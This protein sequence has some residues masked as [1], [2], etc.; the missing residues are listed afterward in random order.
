MRHGG[1]AL[2]L[3][4]LLAAGSPARGTAQCADGSPPPCRIARPALDSARY[5]ILPFAH[6]EG[7]QA[8][9][10]LDGADCAEYLSESFGR[11]SD[12]RLI[13]KTRIYDA[14]ERRGARAPFRIAFGTGLAIARELGAGRVV[15]GQLWSSADTLHLTV[16]VY[17]ASRGGSP[18]REAK[19]RVAANTTRATIAFDALADSLLGTDP[20]GFH[21]A[22]VEETHSIGALR[23]YT[24]GARAIRTWD[25]AGATQHLRAAIAADS[26][27]ARAYVALGQVLLWAADSTPEAMR[28]RGTIARRAGTLLERLAATDRSL[29]LAQQAMFERR[30]PDACERY[31]EVLQRDSSDF[32][33]W[34]GLAQCNAE[35]PVVIRDPADTTRF[36]FRGSWHTAALAYSKALVLAPSFNFAFGTR[37]RERLAHLLLSE[38]FWWREGRLDT[39]PYF[40]FPELEADTVAFHPISGAAMAHGRERPRTQAQALARNRRLLV[41]I[42]GAWVDA[43][44]R[45]PVAH[46]TLAYALEVSGKITP[47]MGEPRTALGEMATAQRLERRSPERAHDAVATVRLL[48]KG[49]D[50][51]AARRVGDSLLRTIRAPAPGV[52]G[53]A[54]LLGRPTLASRLVALEDTSWLH[55][56]ADNEPVSIPLNASLAGLR[57]LAYAAVAAP[58]ESI[59]VLERRIEALLGT[60]PMARRGSARSALLDLP[61]ELV[62]DVMGLRSAHRTTPPGP[63]A[64]MATQWALAHGDTAF[65]RANLDTA[66]ASSHE[67]AYLMARSFVALGDTTE[68]ERYLDRTLENLPQVYSALLDYVPLAGGLIRMMALRAELAAAR[69]EAAAAH[70]WARAVLTLWSGSEAGLQPMV[71]RMTRIVQATK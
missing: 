37:A 52:M 24:R 16:G 66:A 39:V 64:T 54:V 63:D 27:F 68:A 19:A 11:W 70:R 1:R 21:G 33:A 56:S 3:G 55:G 47:T 58:R 71:A 50:F 67:Y 4:V 65:V 41:D 20:E 17:D 28:D 51:E 34:Y 18:L 7:S 53:V 45:D 13:D 26:G 12:V 59:Q 9:K 36:V 60:L 29:L 38:D 42:T 61:A 10:L 23:S 2:L 40:A 31:R 48:F 44:P 49:G 8:T 69:S 32:D 25:L 46:R 62:F 15:M 6:R 5:V 30:W 35:D 14:L 43:F 22:G 57:L